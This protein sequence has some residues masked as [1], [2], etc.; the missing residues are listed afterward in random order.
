MEAWVA[1]PETPGPHPA[2]LVVH[3]IYG[4]VDN[5][6]PILER[7]ASEGYVAFAP[8]LY[9][10]QAP[11]PVCVTRCMLA[12][13]RGKGEA[14]DDLYA[15][16]DYLSD[17]AQ[18][19]SGRMAVTGFCMGGGFALV[20]AL[21]ARVSAAAP[22]YGVSDSYLRQVEDSCPVVASYGERDLVFLGP[23]TELKRRLVQSGIDHDHKTYPGVGHSFMAKPRGTW[24]ERLGKLGPMRVGYNAEA[25]DDAWKRMLSFFRTHLG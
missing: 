11:R 15:A 25:A 2:V 24:V 22:F 5:L 18:V 3:E 6:E 16:L 21:D 7:F 10:R 4:L 20:M 19:D 14:V 17:D 1:R 12:M 9:D 23:G 13:R 8:N